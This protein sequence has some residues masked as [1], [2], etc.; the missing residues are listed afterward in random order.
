MTWEDVAT[1]ACELPEVEPSTSYGTPALK[2]RGKLLTRLRPEDDS[3]VLLGI[4]IDER[5]ML[6]EAAPHRFHVTPHY[7]NY[8]IVLLRLAAAEPETVRAF[9]ERRWRSIAPKRTVKAFDANR[10]S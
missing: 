5:E 4:P 3:L 7:D 1:L 8:P 9:L 2:A 10:R 6:I